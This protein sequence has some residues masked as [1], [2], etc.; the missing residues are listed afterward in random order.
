MNRRV[1]TLIELL[2]VLMIIGIMTVIVTTTLKRVKV[3]T[4]LTSMLVDVHQIEQGLDSYAMETG[5]KSL[6]IGG[7]VGV[8]Q[9]PLS[10]V[11]NVSGYNMPNEEPFL[12]SLAGREVEGKV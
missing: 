5:W 10:C 8:G 12:S 3:Q 11:A 4:L 1:F 2:I 7:W 6:G 9:Y